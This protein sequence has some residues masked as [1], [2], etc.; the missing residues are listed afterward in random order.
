[1]CPAERGKKVVKRAFVPDVDTSQPQAPLIPVTVEQIVISDGSV[2]QI[3]RLYPG[4]I[5]IIV[6]RSRGRYLNQVRRQ[7]CSRARRRQWI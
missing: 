2:K 3:P 5:V 1:M 7:V 4:R 6:L